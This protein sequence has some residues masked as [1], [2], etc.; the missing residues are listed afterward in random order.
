MA[1]GGNWQYRLM[2]SNPEDDVWQADDSTLKVEALKGMK[3]ILPS[4][5]LLPVTHKTVIDTDLRIIEYQ[6][7]RV[8]G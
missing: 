8:G 3:K 5:L 7:L 1:D 2:I 6:L 4:S